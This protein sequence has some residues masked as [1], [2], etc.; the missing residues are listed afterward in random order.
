M[1]RVLSQDLRE[2]VILRSRMVCEDCKVNPAEHMH[3]VSYER[4]GQELPEDIEHLC[5][6]CHGKRHPKHKFRTKWEQRQI[7][8]WRSGRK[9][10]KGR[11]KP[12]FVEHAK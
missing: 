6:V 4:V 9:N 10:R 7:A 2:A 5:V 12:R 3:H 1:A 8:M 11:R